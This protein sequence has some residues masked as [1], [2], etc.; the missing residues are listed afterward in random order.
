MPVERKDRS[1]D[2]IFDEVDVHNVPAEFIMLVKII[3]HS[4]E[5]IEVRDL[6]EAASLLHHISQE[7]VHDVH[8][9]LDYEKIK[10]HVTGEIRS[11]L[12]SHFKS[13]DD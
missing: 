8:I 1:F 12:N 4:G 11:V 6:E 3:L 13:N 9:S 7:E 2:R 10:T 5:T